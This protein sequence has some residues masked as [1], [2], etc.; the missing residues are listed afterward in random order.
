MCCAYVHAHADLVGEAEDGECIE[1]VLPCG[2]VTG[3]VRK[4]KERRGGRVR[5]EGGKRRGGGQSRGEEEG[6]WGK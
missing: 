1:K 3:T 4:A 2:W 5:K 6:G